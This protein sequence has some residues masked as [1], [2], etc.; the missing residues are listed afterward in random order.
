MRITLDSTI[1]IRAFDNTGGLARHL[2][3]AILTGGHPLILS[4]EILAETARVLRYPRMRRRHG[5]PDGNIYEYVIAPAL[6]S[7]DGTVGS[8]ADRANTRSE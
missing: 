3:T 6:G 5:M 1:L 2:L 4:G 8:A 7:L